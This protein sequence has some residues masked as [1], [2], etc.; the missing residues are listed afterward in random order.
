MGDWHQDIVV[1][2]VSDNEVDNVAEQVVQYLIKTKIISDK[3]AE[4][5]LS[6]NWGFCPG[7]N[8]DFVVDYAQEKHFLELIT[9]GMEIKKGRTVFW[10]GG[11]EFEKIGCPNCGEN[12]LGCDW[13][14]LFSKW[15]EDPNSAN[16]E[17]SKC[18][19]SNSISEYTFEP[20]WA[21]SNLGFTFWNW[22][23]FKVSFLTKL[24]E[25]TGKKIELVEGKL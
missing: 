14:E 3:K 15:I 22:P 7:E 1:R 8:W 6:E 19:E 21:L 10:A 17:C 16:L 2:N 13:G 18:G 24:E 23:L 11:Q 5:V 9:N 20:K 4:N 25:L 12:N